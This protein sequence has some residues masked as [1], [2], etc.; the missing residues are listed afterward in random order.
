MSKRS[1][2]RRVDDLWRVAL[3]VDFRAALGI[4]HDTSLELTLDGRCIMLMVG[5][6]RCAICGAAGCTTI[7]GGK[8]IC[9]RCITI[10]KKLD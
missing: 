2:S 4:T 3:P 8:C 7:I 1:V 6:A 9:E 10:I 5:E